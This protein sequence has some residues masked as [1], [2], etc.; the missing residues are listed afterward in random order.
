MRVLSATAD[1]SMS[2]ATSI[3]RAYARGQKLVALASMVDQ[4]EQDIVLRKDIAD[5]AH[6]DPNAPLAT[7]ARF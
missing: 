1:F 2:S 6:F 3:T 4:S 5:A 7:R